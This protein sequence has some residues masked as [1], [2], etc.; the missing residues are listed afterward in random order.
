MPRSGVHER[1][2]HRRQTVNAEQS[3]QPHH[4]GAGDM[5]ITSG[6]GPG[7]PIRLGGE[8]GTWVEA[9]VDA[10]VER[11]VD[12]VSDITFP[13]QLSDEFL[14]VSWAES[15]QR[16]A[17]GSTAANSTTPSGSG[18]CRVSWR[19]SN[20]IAPSAGRPSMPPTMARAGATTW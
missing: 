7:D 6:S 17:R 2:E 12:L 3:G 11:V 14:G 1:Y 20:P 5:P 18:R 8:P 15:V 9:L 16:S 10:S 13:T 4:P 19:S